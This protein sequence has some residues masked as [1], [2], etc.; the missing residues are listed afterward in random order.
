MPLAGLIFGRVPRP[1]GGG[2]S[3]AGPFGRWRDPREEKKEERAACLGL[4]MSAFG[5][6][7][8]DLVCGFDFATV[9]FK[10]ILAY[11]FVPTC[12]YLFSWGRRWLAIFA[13]GCDNPTNTK[14]LLASCGKTN[15]RRCA[16]ASQPGSSPSTPCPAL[17]FLFF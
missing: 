13:G 5:A 6:L 11:D 4:Q 12:I 16:S 8:G 10:N 14:P 3:H 1:P 2:G 7:G 9:F 15:R 17:P